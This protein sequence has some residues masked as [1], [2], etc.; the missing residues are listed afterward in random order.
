[1]TQS[2]HS[3]NHN[4]QLISRRE[5]IK[6]L[7][8]GGGVLA[9]TAFLPGKWIKPVIEAGVLP[10]H[11]QSSLVC[12][13][14]VSIIRVAS[15][16]APLGFTAYCSYTPTTTPPT[17]ISATIGNLHVTSGGL[18]PTSAGN[19]TFN[20]ANDYV[21]SPA[22]SVLRIVATFQDNCTASASF[23]LQLCNATVTI[24]STDFAGQNDP[25][26][27]I[28]TCSYTPTGSPPST[29]SATWGGSSVS[30]ALVLDAAGS[31]HFFFDYPGSP[32]MNDILH[33]DVGFQNNCTASFDFTLPVP[34]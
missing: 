18:T 4:R 24:L 9:A 30:T 14:T 23:S 25:Y 6:A 19:F 5:A 15:G 7:A 10:A 11:A 31:F 12:D 29:L 20:F 28:A 22:D 1:M 13:A 32:P 26:P 21:G 33:I 16:S 8:A 17:S 34:Q 27:N 3:I 2:D